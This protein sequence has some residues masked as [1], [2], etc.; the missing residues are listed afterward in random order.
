VFRR[1]DLGAGVRIDGPCIVDQTD[2]TTFVRLG[3]H[4]VS[5][6]LGNLHLHRGDAP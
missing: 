6:D 4:G 1:A 2:S 5:D 3:W